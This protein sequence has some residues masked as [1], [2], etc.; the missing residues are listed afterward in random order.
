M[1]LWLG[2]LFTF[3]ESLRGTKQSHLLYPFQCFIGFAFD[4]EIASYLAKTLIVDLYCLLSVCGEVG[5][6]KLS[7]SQS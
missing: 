6:R 5:F 2:I 4:S 3:A 1:E 7:E